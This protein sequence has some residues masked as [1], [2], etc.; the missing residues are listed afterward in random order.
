MTTYKG[1]T[2]NDDSSPM[3]TTTD[4]INAAKHSPNEPRIFLRDPNIEL[5]PTIKLSYRNIICNHKYSVKDVEQSDI[6]CTEMISLLSITSKP[7]D[8]DESYTLPINSQV[9]LFRSIRPNYEQK[10]QQSQSLVNIH[11]SGSMN[12]SDKDES[13]LKHDVLNDVSII[14]P[15]DSNLPKSSASN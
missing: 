5:F 15:I 2:C 9:D 11:S 12:A 13:Q 1:Y 3:T 4:S 10:E 6:F 7:K 8:H 14:K